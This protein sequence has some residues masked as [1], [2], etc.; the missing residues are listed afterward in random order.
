MAFAARSRGSVQGDQPVAF[1]N[2]L[3]NE[4]LLTRPSHAPNLENE[5]AAY[6]DLAEQLA[7]NPQRMLGTLVERAVALC[8]AGSAGVSLL[9]EQ[10]GADIIFRWVALAG[11][12]EAYAG[13]QTP[14]GSSPCGACLDRDEPCLFSYPGR[15]F[16][17]FEGVD[18][19]I[20]EG[21]VLPLRAGAEIFGTIWI[22]SHDEAA[23]FDSEDVR[24]MTGLA[25]FTAAAL[26]M[27][28]VNN[29][30]VE[31]SARLSERNAALRSEIAERRRVEE[32]LKRKSA[33]ISR[34]NAELQQFA[35]FTSHDL[36]APLRNILSYVQ[37]LDRRAAHLDEDC[38]EFLGYIG[39]G[40][41]RMMSLI[42]DVLAFS[43]VVNVDAL[44]MTEVDS[45]AAV[46]WALMNL[47]PTVEERGAAIT[48]SGL[49]RIIANQT[50]LV[51]LFQ[52]L[53][54][55]ALKY[56]SEETPRIEI[57][58]EEKRGEWL[59]C[60][61]DNGV[62]IEP[63]YH[64]RIFGVFKRLHG[65]DVPGSGIGLAICKKIVEAH[66]GSIWVESQLGG[67]SSFFFTLPV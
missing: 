67:G 52:N 22:V 50:Q 49:P 59:F 39:G 55:N 62:G 41:Q 2:V 45:A 38:K 14:R 66:D 8:R 27:N 20:V 24:I 43:R 47:R 13:G 29:R 1:Q 54:D 10:P 65:P 63:L 56:R 15:L 23:R 53:I 46:D 9:E 17:V 25:G 42:Q 6:R 30:L 51:Q 34:S 26:R 28:A 44:A 12:L 31:E 4:L 11:R 32:E 21:L 36:Q 64:E 60:V 57:T 35:Y 18:P 61:R 58:A 16:P 40:A 48:V 5:N 19:A 33:A 37:L 3:C 7:N